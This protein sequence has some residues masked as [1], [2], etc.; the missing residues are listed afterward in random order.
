MPA[1]ETTHLIKRAEELVKRS[2][3]GNF[4]QREPG[5]ILVFC[6]LGA[7]AILLISLKIY[8]KASERAAAKV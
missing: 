7:I 6:I 4:A 2:G 8:K 5:V 3:H 1:I